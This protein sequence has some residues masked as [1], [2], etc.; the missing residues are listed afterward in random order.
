MRPWKVRG[1]DLS[2]LEG[3]EPELAFAF[4]HDEGSNGDTLHARITVLRAGS[5][6]G[7]E[8]AI[9]SELGSDMN[10][11]FGFVAN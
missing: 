11:W 3:Q 6:G 7:S 8:F 10:V 9:V 5:Y 2:A 1:A 4:D